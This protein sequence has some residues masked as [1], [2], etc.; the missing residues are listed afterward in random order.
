MLIDVDTPATLILSGRHSLGVS[1]PMDTFGQ[2]YS[3]NGA[4]L[5]V[6]LV[7]RGEVEDYAT[8]DDGWRTVPGVGPER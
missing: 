4:L 5:A 2:L 3:A 1:E 8:A 6:D 7:G